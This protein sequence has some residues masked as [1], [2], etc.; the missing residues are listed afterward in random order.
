MSLTSAA[1]YRVLIIAEAANPNWPSVPLVGWSH[2]AALARV[3]DVHVV[4]QVRNLP[5]FREAGWR[6]GAD[7]TAI[8]SEPAARPLWKFDSAV[9]SLTG[10]GWT[11]STAL[12]ALPYYYFEHMVWRAFGDRIR[13]GEFAIVHR[14]T[15][16]TPTTPS[17]I[18]RRCVGAGARFVWGPINGGVAWPKEFDQVRRQEGEW[19]SYVR[20]AYKLLPGYHSTRRCASAILVGSLASRDQLAP[21]AQARAIY[22]PENAIDPQRFSRQ[23]DRPLTLPLRVAFVGRLVPYKGADMLLEAAA[24]LLREGRVTLDVIGDGPEMPRLKSLAAQ[25]GVADRVRLDGWVENTRL[26]ERLVESDVL[27]F[28]SV[29]EFGGGVVLEAMALGLVPI[30]VDYAGPAELVS[31]ATGFR[32]ALGTRAEIVVRVRDVLSRLL[33]APETVRAIG[34]RAR[35]RVFSLFTW[36]HKAR[37]TLAVYEWVLGRGPRPELGAPFPDPV[38]L[39]G[40]RI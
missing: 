27:G 19:L 32:V 29:R 12:S 21:E 5:A 30:V 25:L 2:A 34:R 1:P 17:R 20:D 35:N 23:V 8:D 16:L 9:R 13:R 39:E 7:F 4:T 10:L 11:A 15:P 38:D 26:Q 18:A 31:D 37:Q 6:E 40:Y 36:D 28:P 33:S 14:L 22:I 24:P 3:A